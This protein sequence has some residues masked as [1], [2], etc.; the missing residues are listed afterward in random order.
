MKKRLLSV[1]IAL[2]LSFALIPSGLVT[3][4]AE[5]VSTDV[6]RYFYDQLD[7]NAKLIYDGMVEM[8]EQDIFKTGT[9]VYEFTAAEYPALQPLITAHMNGSANILN[10]YAAARDAFYADYPDIFYV[11]FSALTVK[12]TSQSGEY[13]LYLGPGRYDTYYT[14]GFENVSDVETALSE[15][16]AALNTLVAVGSAESTPEKKV[17]AVHDYITKHVTY[18][19]ELSVAPENMG[20]VRTAYGALVK[21]EGV[22]ESYTRA[23]KAAMD[24]LGIPCV[25]VYGIYRHDDNVA[26]FHIWNEVEINGEWFAVDVTMDD[27]INPKTKDTSTGED[28]YENHKYMLVGTSV[29]ALNH[30]ESSQ[31]SD[32]GFKFG[33]PMVGVDAHGFTDISDENSPLRIRYKVNEFE[34]IEAG[35]FYVSY[36]GMN[37]NDMIKNGYYLIMRNKVFDV[38]QGWQN[39]E[40]YYC[41][42]EMYNNAGFPTV[43]NET[44]FYMG[45]VQYLEFGVTTIP[46][47][48][49]PAD[50]SQ[51]LSYDSYFHGD[52]SLLLAD[53]GMIENEYGDYRPAPAVM[54]ADPKMTVTL[55]IGPTYHVK[56][57]Y[58]DILVTPEVYAQYCAPGDVTAPGYQEALRSATVDD[59]TVRVDVIDKLTG[60]YQSDSYYNSLIGNFALSFEG[61]ETVLEFDFKPSELWADDNVLYDFTLQGLVGAYSGKE[62]SPFNYGA[63][64]PCAICSWR[65]R[66]FDYNVFAKP[67]LVDDSDLSMEGWTD[68]DGNVWEG[69][70]W[71]EDYKSRLMLVVSD[72]G[73]KDAHNME[74]MVEGK[75]ED[76]LSAL[77]YNINLT[78]CRKQWAELG[79]GMSVRIQ[80]GF[81]EGF[82]PEDEGITFKAYHFNKDSSGNIIGIEEI[83]CTITKYGLLIEVRMFSPFAIVAVRGEPDPE[84][85]IELISD[86]G[87]S[88]SAVGSENGSLVLNPGDT[89]TVTV[90]ADSGYVID[91]VIA[92]GLTKNVNYSENGETYS[93]EV[94]Y[95]DIELGATIVSAKFIASSVASQLE[96]E[97]VI[98]EVTAPAPFSIGTTTVSVE[99]GGSLVLRVS[100]PN[101]A[102]AY[103]WYQVN[104]NGEGHDRMV[105][106]GEELIISEADGKYAGTYYVTAVAFAGGSTAST[107]SNDFVTVNVTHAHEYGKQGYA[108]G[109]SGHYFICNV[110]EEHSEIQPHVYNA[111]GVCGYCGHTNDGTH[112]HDYGTVYYSAGDAGHYQSCS[113]VNADGTVCGS[114]TPTVPHEYGPDGK[115][116]LCNHYNDA[117]H[118]HTYGDELLY[119]DASGHYT[120]CTHI[121]PETGERCASRTALLPH[122]TQ[123]ADHKCACGYADVTV[124]H[125][126]GG[127]VA[128]GERGHYKVCEVCGTHS[129]VEEHTYGDD[130]VCT[131]CG[132]VNDAAHKHIYDDEWEYDAQGHYQV[133]ERLMQDGSACPVRKD[134][135]EH[136][137][138]SEGKCVCG[139]VNDAVH[140]HNTLGSYTADGDNGHYRYCT[141]LNADGTV[142]GQRTDIEPHQYGADGVCALC[143]YVSSDTHVHTFGTEL[144]YDDASGH[145]TRCTHINPVTGLQ[146][147]VR[148]QTVPHDT[149][150]AAHKCVCGY[151]APV[152]H[153]HSYLL[154]FNSYNHWYQCGVCGE[155]AGMSQHTFVNGVCT[156]CRL[157]DPSAG[158]EVQPPETAPDDSGVE[159]EAPTEGRAQLTFAE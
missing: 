126:Y 75:G 116:T 44:L 144:F 73:K 128:D 151:T 109:D 55:D 5:A 51:I 122:D 12:I 158:A 50:H 39:T 35:T 145:Y 87:G 38:E 88:V 140:V 63:A 142:C 129:P 102:Y 157:P 131:A 84:K 8:Y 107:K 110:C 81:P 27:P 86:V 152:S 92:S 117:M 97:S 34:D 125:T 93:F 4:T 18:R 80:L 3:K 17:E 48:P 31:M 103:Q 36:M 138:D 20:F 115:C 40:W 10:D 82:G 65:S 52:T 78:L 74:E 46:Y 28:G 1:L 101:N 25:V 90:T 22:C 132:F 72:T 76:V 23:F 37:V 134:Y 21:H 2:C 89:A 6:S 135:A 29:M 108:S 91:T 130:G 148:S 60:K 77:T 83:P 98:P 24:K 99:N 113:H 49:I 45:H 79:D 59:I 155:I 150:N 67:T 111:Q 16:N 119:D 114:A 121:N 143:K 94:S 33:Y 66:G 85:R 64:H 56:A 7:S 146:C 153:V 156:V 106:T 32:G 123:N 71:D 118:T 69:T 141:H 9:G 54:K 68:S 149:N 53:S 96:G 105:G 43:G 70:K 14:P 15:Y 61:Q 159:I 120:Q 136:R 41:I 127:Y 137:Y 104:G 112:E 11:D 133:C 19:D 139:Y 154:N 42:P 58:N 62:P 95:D 57:Y 124:E 47:P 147:T 26:E 100:N 13:H 30:Q